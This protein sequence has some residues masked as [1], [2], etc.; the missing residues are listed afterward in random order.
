MALSP[1]QVAAQ[2]AADAIRKVRD[3]LKT[4]MTPDEVE[5]AQSDL[6]AAADRLAKK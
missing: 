4:N 3:S 5:K 1:D 2:A 6:N